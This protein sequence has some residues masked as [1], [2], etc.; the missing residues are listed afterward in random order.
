M[1]P[2]VYQSIDW[3]L[4]FPIVNF[5]TLVMATV[6]SVAVERV[7]ARDEDGLAAHDG[8]QAWYIVSQYL[9]Q[10]FIWDLFNS[11]TKGSKE[12]LDIVFQPFIMPSSGVVK[13]CEQF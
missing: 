11:N 13:T 5:C 3:L 6:S 8:T 10:I 4:R 2:P 9:A 12:W 7:V 1:P